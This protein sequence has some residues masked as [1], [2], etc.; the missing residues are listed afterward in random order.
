MRKQTPVK[1][2]TVKAAQARN[3]K[4]PRAAKKRAL[5]KPAQQKT[6]LTKIKDGL[7]ETVARL[8]MLLPGEAKSSH[9]DKPS[10]EIV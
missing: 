1:K 10:S 8:K 3:Q 4:S 7:D 9:P 6:V 2:T 5:R